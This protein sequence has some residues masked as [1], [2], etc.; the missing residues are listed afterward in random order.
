MKRNS[1]RY[2]WWFPPAVWFGCFAAA[3]L[4]AVGIGQA[5]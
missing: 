3:A 2:P 5:A 1:K 4:A